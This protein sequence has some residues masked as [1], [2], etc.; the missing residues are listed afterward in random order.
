M[1]T[2]RISDSVILR[3]C[4]VRVISLSTYYYY[5]FLN[6]YAIGSKIIKYYYYLLL[7]RCSASSEQCFYLYTSIRQIVSWLV[8]HVEV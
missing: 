7:K 1:A 5:F 3:H 8:S 4:G 2:A 6:F